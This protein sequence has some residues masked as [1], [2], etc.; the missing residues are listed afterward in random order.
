MVELRYGPNE[1]G[2]TDFHYRATL[3]IGFAGKLAVGD[4]D[5]DLFV[6]HQRTPLVMEKAQL[7]TGLVSFRRRAV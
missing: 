7:E 5:C 4:S 1:P 3:P 2:V 6:G